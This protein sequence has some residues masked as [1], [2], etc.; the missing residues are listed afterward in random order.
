TAGPSN[1]RGRTS[2]TAVMRTRWAT[3]R[4]DVRSS[5]TCASRHFDVAIEALYL[6]MLKLAIDQ[7]RAAKPA[8]QGLLLGYPDLIVPRAA[9]SQ[10]VGD[11]IVARLAT[12][13]GAA[14]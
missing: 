4:R 5:S 2:R 1:F 12:V 11:E 14:R 13:D 3:T 7:R 10:L 9:L 8:M 6:R